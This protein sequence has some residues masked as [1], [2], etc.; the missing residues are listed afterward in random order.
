MSLVILGPQRPKANVREALDAAGVEGPVALIT[1]G[2][3][4][5]EGELSGF[6][7]ELNN[8]LYHLPV[9]RWFD[10]FM[11]SSSDASRAYK[12]RQSEIRRVKEYYRVRLHSALQAA[13]ILQARVS[14]DPDLAG[15]ELE[16]AIEDVR[17]IDSELIE[18][19]TAIRA[20]YPEVEQ[21]WTFPAVTERTELIREELATCQAVC[22]AGGH[23]AVLRNRMLFF[24]MDQVLGDFL[25]E[26]RV[27]ACWSAG[28]M[29]LTERIVLFY[30][31]PP[32]GRG[33]PEVLD[34]GLGL[35]P[36]LVL[37]PHAK[38]R[39]RVEDA[40]RVSLLA[41]RMAPNTCVGL[42]NGARLERT[43]Q[44]W[45]NRGEP[46]AAVQFNVDGSVS[47]FGGAA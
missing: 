39:L 11:R 5:D 23:V 6:K 21:P 29:A 19:T 15:P 4:H 20:R 43:E 32:E 24:G 47:P 14:E 25:G 1:A 7:S 35:L 34:C 17:R 12:A 3:R 30:D 46:S 33:E 37:F 27:L 40:S 31:D 18:R 28:A 9:Y 2:W 36:G 41:R 45:L 38:R 44:G 42:E 10:D 13:Q 22:L 16:R 8:T 26:G